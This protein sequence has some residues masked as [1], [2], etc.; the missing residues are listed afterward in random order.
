M[1]KAEDTEA[2]N[3]NPYRPPP[4]P[5]HPKFKNPGDPPEPLE[6]ELQVQEGQ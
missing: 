1:L 2:L 6:E 5:L 3:K 4:P